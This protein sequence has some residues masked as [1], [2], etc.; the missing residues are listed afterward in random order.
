MVNVLYDIIVQIYYILK[1]NKKQNTEQHL[2]IIVQ[3][4][5]NNPGLNTQLKRPVCY[6]CVFLPASVSQCVTASVCKVR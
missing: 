5:I 4:Q 6:H 2:L 3:F 1:K